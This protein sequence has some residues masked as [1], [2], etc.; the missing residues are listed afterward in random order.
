MTTDDL[1]PLPKANVS[2]I[3]TEEVT[4]GSLLAA[5]MP[6]PPDREANGNIELHAGATE[7]YLTSPI[8]MAG[9][10][11]SS[12]LQYARSLPDYIDDATQDFGPDLYERMA[13]DPH[14]RGELNNYKLAVL[15]GGVRLLP[16]F[17]DSRDDVE[18]Q[19][20]H[21]IS[22]AILQFCQ[23][24][25]DELETPID[26]VLDDTLSCMYLGNRL[27][28]IVYRRDGDYL[29]LDRLA[30]KHR[31]SYA[32]V[33]D[34]RGRTIGVLGAL[35]GQ[36]QT[37][38]IRPEIVVDPAKTPNL[39]P[40]SKFLRMSWRP[41]GGDPRGTSVLRPAYNPWWQ[42]RQTEVELAKY[43]AQFAGS[44]LVIT[45]PEN[46]KPVI[47]RNPDGTVAKDANGDNILDHPSET[48]LSAARDYKN[49]SVLILPFGSEY[50]NIVTTGAGTPFFE[51]LERCD[52]EIS[53]AILGQSLATNE[54][55]H[56]ARAAS[57]GQKDV[58]DV[59]IQ[60]GEERL[61]A[62]LRRVLKLLI[63]INFGPSYVPFTPYVSLSAAEEA[64]VEKLATAFSLI[65]Y[66]MAKSQLPQ[67]D[68]KL[69]FAPRS[70][71]DESMQPTPTVQTGSQQPANTNQTEPMDASKK[72]RSLALSSST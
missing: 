8:A 51:Q 55:Q 50:G 62:V 45:L 66:T 35:A 4:D 31:R 22:Q 20:K 10:D 39:L 15:A 53:K 23:T 63:E 68:I 46:A 32:Y 57:S 64:D 40:M 47:R 52:K 28:E 41:V 44:G 67:A 36:A 13:L 6:P 60:Y 56:Q 21:K 61:S 65:G 3:L 29:M 70:E 7:E 69:G 2:P 33:S 24:A 12:A 19:R 37:Q 59:L 11:Y 1:Q 30:I 26:E 54:G 14:I 16:A 18:Q 72:K 27:G 71:D 34:S 42:K 25:L 48:T 17:E 38:V 43:I 9:G 58:M 5:P 49:G